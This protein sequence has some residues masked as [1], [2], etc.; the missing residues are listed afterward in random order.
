MRRLIELSAIVADQ[1]AQPRTSILVDKVAE[2]TEDMQRGDKFPPLVVFYDGAKYW[3]ADG[4][5]RYYAASGAEEK[6]LAC[7]VH[8]GTLRDAI[9][10]SCGANSAHGVRRTNQ[11]KQRAVAKLLEDAE[12]SHWSDAEIARRCSVSDPMVAKL[13]K[14]IGAVTLN[15]QS[16]EPRTYVTKHGTETVMNTAA[17]GRKPR[18]IEQQPSEIADTLEDIR[19]CIDFMPEA[20][21]A[22]AAFP[23]DKFYFFP[24]SELD[25]MAKWMVDFAAAWR[26]KMEEKARAA[27]S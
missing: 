9:L 7:D 13:R 15:S 25:E 12:W 4:F 11:D 3:L 5:H 2:Y 16:E 24:L 8:D 27:A 1:K 18:E 23:A 10:Y 14:E 22:V 6:S 19:R 17:I 26:A 20:R 21:A